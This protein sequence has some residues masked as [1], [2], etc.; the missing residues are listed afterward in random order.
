MA[1]RGRKADLSWKLFYVA[2]SQKC[3]DQLK[4][5]KVVGVTSCEGFLV[6][7]IIVLLLCSLT[8]AIVTVP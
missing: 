3:H 7:I 4:F 2:V 5:A 1:D 8:L 6:S